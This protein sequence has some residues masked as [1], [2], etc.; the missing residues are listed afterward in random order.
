MG[1]AISLQKYLNGRAVAYEVMAHNRTS[2]SLA[3]AHAS[4]IPEDNLA[5]GVLIRRKDGY[6]LAIVPASCNV[7]LDEVGQW[8]KQPVGLA[9]EEEIAAIF[10]DCKSGCVPV[11]GAYGLTSVMDERLEGFNDIY[12]EGGDHR[13]L[14]HMTGAEFHR[15]MANVPHALVGDRCQTSRGSVGGAA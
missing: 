4:S 6:L 13:T 2:T 9:T 7:Q 3:T 5:K 8:L 10:G 15:L 12:F 11:A 14:V 1:I